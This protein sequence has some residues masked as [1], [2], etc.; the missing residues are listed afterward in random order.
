M[1]YV[2]TVLSKSSQVSDQEFDLDQVKGKVVTTKKVIVP[3]F[4]T[5]IARGLMKVTG[6][7]KHVHVL[8]EPSPRCK[9]IFVPGNT[10]ELIPGGSGVVVLLQNLSGRDITLEPHTEV[11]M[12]TAAQHSSIQKPDKQ[13]LRGN[14]KVQCKSPQADLSKGEIQPEE[15]DP[16]DIFWKI[17]LGIAD[18][19]PMIQQEA[20]D[21][22]HEYA[23]IFLWN[24]LDLGK[25]LIIKHSIILTDP[26]LFKECYRHISPGMNKEVKTHIQELLDV[27][28]I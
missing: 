18:W 5:V 20:H 3:A 9:S 19:D 25:T 27:G 21:L 11:G 16:E 7:Q 28:A 23:C 24:D 22:M 4:Q 12:V 1:A 8:V 17:D 15:T 14:E 10:S 13:D 2:S 6:H 26:T